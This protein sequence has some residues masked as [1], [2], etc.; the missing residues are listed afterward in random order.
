MSLISSARQAIGARTCLSICS[1]LMP[2]LTGASRRESYRGGV[3]SI[4]QGSLSGSL[5]SKSLAANI[6]GN[7]LEKVEDLEGL[8]QIDT[9]R[10]CCRILNELNCRSNTVEQRRTKPQVVTEPIHLC[11]PTGLILTV[12]YDHPSR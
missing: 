3:C 11:S 12:R 5:C 4:W 9:T 2:A 8:Y 10:G 1:C 7:L 6:Y